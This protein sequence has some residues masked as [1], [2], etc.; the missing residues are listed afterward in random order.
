MEQHIKILSVL[1]I[2]FGVIGMVAAVGIFVVG[3]GTGAT[4]LASDTGDDAQIGAAWVTGCFTF[5]AILLAILAVPSIVAGWG[6]SQ[7][8]SWAR[9]VTIIIAAISLPHVPVGT[10]LGIY[11]LVVMLNDE[12]KTI[13][14]A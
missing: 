13:L 9:I 5:M 7:R 11:A 6:L 14:T 2:L 1:F 10:A 4:I 12:T 3:A 8:K